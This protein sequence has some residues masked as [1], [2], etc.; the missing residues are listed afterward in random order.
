[1][2]DC[3]LPPLTVA[4]QHRL[5]SAAMILKWAGRYA[6]PKKDT[7]LEKDEK[8][9]R[10]LETLEDQ[11]LEDNDP[12]RKSRLR[13]RTTPR[14]EWKDVNRIFTIADKELRRR[15]ALSKP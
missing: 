11:A 7:Q 14:L 1:M 2:G 13:I 4:D 10:A 8:A 9:R 3:G 5:L 6:A 12:R 15:Y